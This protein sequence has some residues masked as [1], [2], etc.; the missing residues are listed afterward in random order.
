MQ[1]RRAVYLYGHNMDLPL[2]V[3]KKGLLKGKEA[4]IVQV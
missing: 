1:L 2:E 3:G 4:I